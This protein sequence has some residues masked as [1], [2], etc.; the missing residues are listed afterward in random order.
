MVSREGQRHG[1]L[2]P[3]MGLVSVKESALRRC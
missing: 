3:W 1:W 2:G